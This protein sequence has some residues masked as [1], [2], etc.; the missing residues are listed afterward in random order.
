M[1][2]KS[3]YR[4]LIPGFEPKPTLMRTKPTFTK[5]RRG[6]LADPPRIHTDGGSWQPKPT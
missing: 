1:N 2:L 5:R 6:H 3:A 4:G